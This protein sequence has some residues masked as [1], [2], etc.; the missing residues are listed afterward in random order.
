MGFL[1][2]SIVFFVGSFYRWVYLALACTRLLRFDVVTAPT[3][4]LWACMAYFLQLINFIL[5]MASS[6]LRISWYIKLE[7]FRVNFKHLFF[8]PFF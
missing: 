3:F 2:I 7:C 5:A 4:C 1:R 6:I 8:N